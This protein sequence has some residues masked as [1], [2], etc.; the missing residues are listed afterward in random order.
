[1]S[2]EKIIYLEKKKYGNNSCYGYGIS[3]ENMAAAEAAGTL[4]VLKLRSEHI[5]ALGGEDGKLVPVAM[6]MGRDGDNYTADE[7][8]VKSMLAAGMEPVFIHYGNVE[9]QL[10][11]VCGLLL[12]GGSFD[13]PKE[14]YKHPELL[15]NHCLN[16]RS[17]AY[18]AACRYALSAGLPVLG[19]CAGHQMMAGVFQPGLQM[20]ARIPEETAVSETHKG[21]KEDY[22]HKVEISKD[23]RLYRILGKSELEVNSNHNEAIIDRGTAYDK[24]RISAVS[25]EGIVE[26]WEARDEK[27]FVLGVQWH[28]EYLASEYRDKNAAR[29]FEVLAAEAYGFCQRKKNP[30][31]F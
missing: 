1:M 26:A 20:Y 17:A 29:L 6:L 7:P 16:S 3:D 31:L 27:I 10:R 30:V 4:P 28:P 15:K 19:I 13:S 24:I 25:P 18:I 14:W 21:H 11:D 8:Y 2:A 5:S 23:S 9:S 12:P 22:I